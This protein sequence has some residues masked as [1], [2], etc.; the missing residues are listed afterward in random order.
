[1][2]KK[3]EI[4]HAFA[5]IGQ[6]GLNMLVPIG[7]S[8]F[9][10]R[11]IDGILGTSFFLIIFIILGILAAYKSLYDITKRWRKGEDDHSDEI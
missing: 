2:K 11:W 9:I 3:Y 8:F 6:I 1:M 4:M 7:L 10:G 5:L